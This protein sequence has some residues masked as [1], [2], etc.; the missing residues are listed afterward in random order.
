MRRRRP[1][2]KP[3]PNNYNIGR[4]ISMHLPSPSP[5][6]SPSPHQPQTN[7]MPVPTI[8]SVPMTRSQILHFFTRSLTAFHSSSHD[9]FRV[10]CTAPHHPLAPRLPPAP[11]GVDTLVV[12]DSSFNPPTRAHAQMAKSAM[13]S[14]GPGARLLLLLAVNNADKGGAG[15][16]AGVAPR[17]GMMEGFA[18]DLARGGGGGGGGG[19]DDAEIEIDVAVTTGALFHE[20]ARSIAGS[21]VYNDRRDGRG[22]VRQVYLCG[23]DTV[24][25]IF[26]PRYY[27]DEPAGTACSCSGASEGEGEG[28]GVTA[29]QRAL[30]PFFAR[31]K[32]RVM[33]RPDDE[34]GSAEEQR[35][36][37]DGL[38]GDGGLERVGGDA[39]WAGRIELVEGVEGV[40]SSSRVREV[41]RRGGGGDELD[42][43]VGEEVRR[44]IEEEG[45]YR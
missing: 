21:G 15:P 25:R 31:A 40:V 8:P 19:G 9:A 38:L 14:A 11:P 18:R 13:E 44:W 24:I 43:M 22:D 6:P 12:L 41:V 4:S 37:V 1:S 39:D 32:L 3:N 17:L 36:W 10:L 35:A 45:L 7:A 34:W 20:K 29:M 33:M 16:A 23:F 42:G 2:L 27:R 30:R 5:S 26:D 28:E